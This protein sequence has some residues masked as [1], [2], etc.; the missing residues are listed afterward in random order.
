MGKLIDETGKKYGKLTVLNRD[1]KP[2]KKP[3]WVCQCECGEIFSVYGTHLR[4]G[5]TT[6]CKKCGYKQATEARLGKLYESFIGKKFN[7][8]T[9][10]NEDF[11]KERGAGKERYWIC[12]CDCGKELS[13]SSHTII[14]ETIFSCGCYRS[15][16]EQIIANILQE[17]NITFEKEK[18]FSDCRFPESGRYARFDFYLP[19]YNCLIEFD[20]RQHYES[21]GG[22]FTDEEIQKIRTRDIFKN[23][24]CNK[25]NI[26]LI[27]IPYFDENKLSIEYLIM[28]GVP[29]ERQVCT[30]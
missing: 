26:K 29:Y 2:H 13:L 22:F 1:P 8:I 20:G 16:G 28:K 7:H 24:W 23:D 6:Q 19:E 30:V 4:M 21:P 5:I 14:H 25:N 15:K 3:Y 10:I 18:T 11:T 12:K 27:R 9:V 17:N